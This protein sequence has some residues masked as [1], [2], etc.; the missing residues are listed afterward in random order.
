MQ[1]GVTHIVDS[2]LQDAKVH[3]VQCLGDMCCLWRSRQW[4]HVVLE[5]ERH[6]PVVQ[7]AH[8]VIPEENCP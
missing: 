3:K 4:K 7:V 6:D 8:H 1:F 5:Q 2:S